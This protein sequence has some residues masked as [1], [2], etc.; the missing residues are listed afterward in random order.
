M[1]SGT[2]AIVLPV[3]AF[4][5]IGFV[6]ARTRVLGVAT[7]DAL[8]EFVYYLGLPLLLFSGLGTLDLPATSPWPFWGAYF[9]AAALSVALGIVANERLFRRDARAG[10]VGGLAS[11]YS[12]IGFIGIPLLTEAYGQEGLVLGLLLIAVHAPAMMTASAVLIEIAEW[13][14][15]AARGTQVRL[16]TAL[17]RVARSLAVN[18]LIIGVVGGVL[19]RLT[20]LPLDGVL[21]EVVDGIA[22][23]AIP[24]ALISLGM[25]LTKFPVRG[26]LRPALTL[27]AIKLLVLPAFVYVLAVPVAGLPPVSAA[28]LVT[29]AACPTGVNAYLIATRFQTGLALAA[30]TITLT[31]AASIVTFTLW[32]SVLAP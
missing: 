11:S 10:V 23:T 7:G 18:P 12:N 3:F 24:L 25:S 6:V 19:F 20:G 4:I 22:G 13:R 30:N 16:G 27:G 14:D 2:V 32:L 28:V 26:D 21:G 1:P 15:G 8:S 31:T 29:A 5:A 9:P 17:V